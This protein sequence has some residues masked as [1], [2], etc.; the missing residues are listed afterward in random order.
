MNFRRQP[1]AQKWY[2]V[3]AWTCDPPR[4]CRGSTVI[5]QTGSVAVGAST[6]PS[7]NDRRGGC[8]ADIG[9]P[10]GAT[11]RGEPVGILRE[12]GST[13]DSP[14]PEGSADVTRSPS[15]RG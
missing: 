7:E 5:P 4:G 2:V 13:N 15:G 6:T 14:R 9:N 1:S 11:V 10:S 12:V 3:P 8:S